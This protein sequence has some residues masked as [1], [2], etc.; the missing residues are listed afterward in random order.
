MTQPISSFNVRTAMLFPQKAEPD[1]KSPELAHVKADKQVN[2]NV[3]NNPTELILQAA[4]EKINKVFKPYLG[5]GVTQRTVESGQDMSPKAVAD[6]IISFATQLIG[7]VESE[8]VDLPA[9]EQRSRA[10]LFDNIKTGVERGFSQARDIL[11]GLS[12][13]KG[14]T[15][16]TVD[17]SYEQ[18]QQGLANLAQ[19]LGLQSADKAQV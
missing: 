13:L 5:D 16:E 11:D 14:E 17:N 3:R 8:Q 7:R 18:V 10:Q 6:R 2:I 15:K 19:L 4:M 12:E 9:D 1:H